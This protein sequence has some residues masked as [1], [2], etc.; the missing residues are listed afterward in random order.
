DPDA[1]AA[2]LQ[3]RLAAEEDGDVFTQTILN[4]LPEPASRPLAATSPARGSGAAVRFRWAR[5]QGRLL[6]AAAVLLAV[7]GGWWSAHVR[8]TNPR[9][10][11]K[12]TPPAYMAVVVKMD[13]AQW[14]PGA[15]PPPTEGSPLPTGPLR[16]RAGRVTLTL[17][18]GV[19]LSLQGPADLDMTSVEHIFC[20]QGKLRARVP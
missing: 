4:R 13:G 3:A 1:F 7:L 19:M 12:R 20:Q 9:T 8:F 5:W 16:L 18:N 6:A 11:E 2:S 14:E 10:E 17:F 15:A